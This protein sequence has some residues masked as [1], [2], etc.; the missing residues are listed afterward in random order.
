MAGGESAPTR[1][2]AV[3]VSATPVR[4]LTPQEEEHEAF[5]NRYVL[6]SRKQEAETRPTGISPW[7]AVTA[8][9]KR[10]LRAHQPAP[11]TFPHHDHHD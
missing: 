3:V 7:L 10:N 4:K 5:K 1:N 6:L 9:R 11:I 8:E 2:G